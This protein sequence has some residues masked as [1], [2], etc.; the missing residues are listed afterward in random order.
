MPNFLTF[1]TIFTFEKY[2]LKYSVAKGYDDW[3]PTLK[4]FTTNKNGELNTWSKI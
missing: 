2:T 4:Y 3:K 1:R